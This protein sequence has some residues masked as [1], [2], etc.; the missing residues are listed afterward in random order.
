MTIANEIER[1]SNAKSAIKTSLANKGVIIPDSAKLDE[2]P[3]Y[4]DSMD[5]NDVFFKW[6]TNNGSNFDGLYAYYYYDIDS[7]YIL[8]P[9]NTKIDNL[10]NLD[11]SNCTSMR[12]MFAGNRT[13]SDYSSIKDWDMS[14]VKYA[15][16]MFEG[17]N[18]LKRI[19]L[20]DWDVTGFEYDNRTTNSGKNCYCM[21]VNCGNLEAVYLAN[22]D[23]SNYIS[24]GTLVNAALFDSTNTSLKELH[25]DNCNATTIKSILNI[26]IPTFTDGKVH[27]V[28]CEE[29]NA[30]ASGI[31]L[32]EGW[33]WS[34]PKSYVKDEYKQNAELKCVYPVVDSTHTDLSNIFNGCTA[35][36][37]VKTN[38]W[39]T[40]NVTN[41]SY[42]FY[43]CIKLTH[44]DLESFN[45]SNVTDMS[46]MFFNFVGYST[47]MLKSFH[48][49]L[50]V[51]NFDTSNVTNMNNMFAGNMASDRCFN[52]IGLENFDTSNVTNISGMFA[53]TQLN[54][55][56]AIANWDVS[57]VTNMGSV[58]SKC[59]RLVRTD[60]SNWD[61]SNVTSVLCLFQNCEA[62]TEVDLSTW[63]L[64]NCTSTTSTMMIFGGCNALHTI[65][66]DNCSNDTINKIITSMSFPTGAC[67][68][69]QPRVI[70]CKEA[71]AQGLTA[72]EGWSFS[73]V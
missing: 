4:I 42:M 19:N 73:F 9:I 53:Q 70:Y 57:N 71:E 22:W 46:H 34:F 69:G 23:L 50:D 3:P 61:V 30:N 55:T 26:N 11:T 60:L 56:D 29:V 32:P 31:T 43:N 64:S 36:E 28:F 20:S 6:R 33:S 37:I 45:T 12:F 24:N 35:L 1:L 47:Y 5:L 16:Y 27:V 48:P 40:S 8:E 49:T 14:K 17:N 62:L 59:K 68:G 63:D 38:T 21:F 13:V 51:S 67:T 39:D 44:I 10:E 18:H 52:I 58:F 65:R 15:A 7:N 25:L 66:L 2:Y 41:M 54:N 72:P